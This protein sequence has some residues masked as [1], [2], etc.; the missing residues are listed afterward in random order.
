MGGTTSGARHAGTC[1]LVGA[2]LGALFT[3]DLRVA[4]VLL[5]LSGLGWI[6]CCRAGRAEPPSGPWLW[7]VALALRLAA[8]GLA[9]EFSDDI[10]RYAWEGEVVLDGK[11]PYGFAPDAPELAPLRQ[12]LP[13]LAARVG[14]PDVPAVYP[15]LAQLCASV[16]A[17]LVHLCGAR[18]GPAN[19]AILR[20]LYLLADLGVLL[21]LVRAA[22]SGRLPAHAAMVWGW[23][24]LVCLEFAGSGHLDSLGILFLLLALLAASTLPARA[25]LWSALGAATKLLP[26]AVLP[27]IGRATGPGRRLGWLGLA[28]L[29]LL[30]SYIPFAFLQGGARGFGL[31]L[32]EYGERWE[33]ASL[34][35][36]FV[37]PFVRD[38]FGQGAPPEASRHLA[39]VLIGLAWLALA[40]LAVWRRPDAW[41]GAGA[42]LGAWL[43]LSPVLHPW[44]VLWILPFVA[45]EASLAWSWLVASAALFYWPLAGWHARKEWIEPAWIWWVV[46]PLFA[47]LWIAERVRAREVR[48]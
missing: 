20:V 19:I 40:G 25:A 8:F 39:R 30:L 9:P 41:S 22:N 6:V 23:C 17:A 36:R 28:L 45:R 2:F 46:A 32:H 18:A 13:E 3:G 29:L 14:H 16:T 44:Y 26:L 42:I 35:Y 5:A 11:S 10:Q 21:V 31:G 24:P 43:V 7:V 48:T 4:A 33:G 47:G 1:L 37:E 38:H 34:V 27:W 12:R 15:P